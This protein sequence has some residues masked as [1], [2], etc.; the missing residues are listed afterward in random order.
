MFNTIHHYFACAAL[1]AV[2][3]LGCSEAAPSHAEL[4]S[5]AT[6]VQ[7][8]STAA[9]ATASDDATLVGEAGTIVSPQTYNTCTKSFVVDIVDSSARGL[10]VLWQ[11]AWPGTASACLSDLE[12]HAK[13]YVKNSSGSWVL[14][15]EQSVVK[16]IWE[17]LS[18]ICFV[19]HI[20]FD[21]QALNKTEFRVAAT[22]RRIANGNPTRKLG[23]TVAE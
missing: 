7:P 9:C 22:A 14:S 12:M 13:L 23:I 11:D 20:S 19:P 4:E 18:A 16:G 15:S 2:H 21:L 1:A 17:P 3:T 6:V 8:Y 10:A 5:T